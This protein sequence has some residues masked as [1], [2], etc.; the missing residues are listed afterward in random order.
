MRKGISIVICSRN[1]Q[2]TRDLNNNVLNTIGCDFELVIINNSGNKYSIFEAYNLGVKKSKYEFIVFLHDDILIHT[3][4]WGK[5]L[6][7]IFDQN[8]EVG[9]I[10]VAGSRIKTS[11]P[12]AW[13][14]HEESYLLLNILQHE[15][16]KKANISRKGF[17]T[18]NVEDVVIIDGVFMAFRKIKDIAFNEDLKGF[19]NYDVNI[20]LETLKKGYRVIVTNKILVEHFSTGAIDKDWIRSSYLLHKVYKEF[21]PTSVSGNII[22]RREKIFAYRRYLVNCRATGHRKFAL[23]YWLKFLFL[24][25]FRKEHLKWFRYFLKLD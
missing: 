7:N 14:E 12:T 1:G 8:R 18:A 2:I 17:K 4:N 3:S 15:E 19:H 22:G 5:I 21:L 13:W 6:L 23:E 9:L 11:I 24:S 10:G 20:S 25:P 16:D